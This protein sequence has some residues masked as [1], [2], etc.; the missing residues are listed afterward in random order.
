MNIIAST[1]NVVTRKLP[2]FPARY[3]KI[4]RAGGWL[5]CVK[6][7]NAATMITPIDMEITDL[8]NNKFNIRTTN[9]TKIMKRTLIAAW[10]I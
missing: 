6:V 8:P 2:V 9:I 10:K 7:M 3:E 5:N 1:N 4:V